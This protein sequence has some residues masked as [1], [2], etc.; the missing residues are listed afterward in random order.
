MSGR[1]EFIK[2]TQ[3]VLSTYVYDNNQAIVPASATVTIY[4]PGVMAKLVDSAPMTIG[5]DGLLS[6]TVTADM[7]QHYISSGR[8]A[9]PDITFISNSHKAVIAYVYNSTT[10]YA[11]LFYDVVN[12]KLTQ[13][14]TDDDV[15]NE[16][17]QLKDRGWKVHGTAASGSTTTIVDPGL[18]RYA[19]D[20]FTGGLAYSAALDQTRAITGFAASTGTVTVAPAFSSAISTDKYI[21]TRSFTKEIRRSFEKIE[22]LLNRT[23][24]RAYLCLDPF[25]L[26]EVHIF[27]SVAE[28]CK[29]MITEENNMWW[30]LWQDY[31]KRGYAIFKSL[32]LK[33]DE[34]D[35]G[36]ITSDEMNT[37]LNVRLGRR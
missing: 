5:A 12:S 14:I 18:T 24:R 31:D 2:D 10:Y 35:D 37:R 21:L 23:G 16:L 34:F 9:R 25:D 7:N 26:R 4:K 36:I 1:L 28:V 32:N 15:I 6:Y 22:D 17:P 20:Y 19:D 11:T 29:G 8:I 30:T 33:Y 13:V 27:F 3:G